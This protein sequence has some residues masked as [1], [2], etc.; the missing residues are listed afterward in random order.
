V[1]TKQNLPFPNVVVRGPRLIT[2]ANIG[3]VSSSSN[4]LAQIKRGT[5]SR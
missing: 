2:K 3:S 5:L 1:L 4:E